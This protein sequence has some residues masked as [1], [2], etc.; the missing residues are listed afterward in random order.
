[1][2][3]GFSK[4]WVKK[5]LCTLFSNLIDLYGSSSKCHISGYNHRR[6]LKLGYIELY[7][8][9]AFYTKRTTNLKKTIFE[10]FKIKNVEF[11][12]DTLYITLDP[13]L[14]SSTTS[15][16]LV[17]PFLI[18]IVGI[19]HSVIFFQVYL[20]L[21]KWESNKMIGKEM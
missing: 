12:L 13:Y 20:G 21:Q 14:L 11:F 19:R 1:M 3:E 16:L 2:I 6:K 5:L 4:L 15:L 17:F 9:T 18:V 10:I 7:G 8:N